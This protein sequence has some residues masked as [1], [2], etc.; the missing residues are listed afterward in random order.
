MDD[1]TARRICCLIAGIVAVD[2]RLEQAEQEYVARIL[3]WFNLPFLSHEDLTPIPT[4]VEAAAELSRAPKEVQD[5]AFE[6][7]V[8]AV[9]ADRVFSDKE[10]GYLM[11]VAAAIG[12][13]E[14]DA[15]RRVEAALGRVVG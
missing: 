12:V 15:S 5:E 4:A 8:Q 14:Q 1:K 9:A 13:A 6:L 10:R 2:G 7:M 3:R 11:T